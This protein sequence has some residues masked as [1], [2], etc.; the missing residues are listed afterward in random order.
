MVGID[1]METMATEKVKQ[2]TY[3]EVSKADSG[4]SVI[5]PWSPAL[6]IFLDISGFQA[7][8]RWWRSSPFEEPGTVSLTLR[9]TWTLVTSVL[10]TESLTVVCKGPWE[11]GLSGRR[12]R[13]GT[14]LKS[15][16]TQQRGKARIS[17]ATQK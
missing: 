16:N 8:W 7:A 15:R 11:N 9:S 2:L 10:I 14:R 4:L 1:I 6:W 3:S 17:W 5:P 13:P 12:K